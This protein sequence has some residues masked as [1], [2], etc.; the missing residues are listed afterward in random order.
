MT[1]LREKHTALVL[2]ESEWDARLSR[3]RQELPFAQ[4]HWLTLGLADAVGLRFVPT[5]V[6]WGRAGEMLLPLCVTDR[7]RRAQ[8]GCYGY[9]SVA[10]SADWRGP[11]PGFADLAEVVCRDQ[12]LSQLSTLVPPVGACPGLDLQLGHWPTRPARNTYLLNLTD[13]AQAVWEAAKGSSRT[14]V[15][16]AGALGLVAS[17]AVP[18]QGV[19]LARL[20]QQTLV[21]NG[22]GSACDASDLEFLADGRHAVTTVV[23]DDDGVQAAS[24]FAVGV[25]DVAGE[26]ST[27]GAFHLM[28]VTSERGRALNA[29]HLAFWSGLTA[30]AE[31]G[32]AAVD[33]GAAAGGGQEKFKSGWGASAVAARAV[34]WQDGEAR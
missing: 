16:R 1:D 11:L 33:L 22:A 26:V 13:G 29:G 20:Q 25:A 23:A 18:G 3:A 24:V 15:R 17:A 19:D 6:R 12:G 21:R 9:G 32:V 14:A 10:V 4:R 28:Q 27:A 5:A 2:T 7:D 34:H 31:R 8:I 30:L